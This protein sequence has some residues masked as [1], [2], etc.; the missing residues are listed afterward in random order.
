MDRAFHRRPYPVGYLVCLLDLLHRPALVDTMAITAVE[1]TMDTMAAEAEA[2][3]TGGMADK[4]VGT[5]I[6]RTIVVEEEVVVV[7]ATGDTS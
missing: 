2:M 4:A 7:V 1:G 6:A 3:E 5:T